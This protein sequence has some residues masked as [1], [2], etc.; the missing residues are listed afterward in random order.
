MNDSLAFECCLWI[1]N[2]YSEE[3]KYMSYFK[4]DYSTQ[5]DFDDSDYKQCQFCIDVGLDWYDED[6]I[7][8]I[9]RFERKVDLDTLLNKSPIKAK[10]KESVKK[11]CVEL[12]IEKANTIFWYASPDF[13]LTPTCKNNYNVLKYIGVYEG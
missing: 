12:G 3:S 13:K 4:L 2:D 11:R 6:F 9:P 7:G 1:G 10:E 5:G 8:I